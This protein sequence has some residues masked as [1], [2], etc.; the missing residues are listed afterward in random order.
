ME[1]KNTHVKPTICELSAQGPLQ[2]IFK[3][4][5]NTR[6]AEIPAKHVFILWICTHRTDLPLQKQCASYYA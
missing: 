2:R 3:V 5:E 4:V 1:K 6:I